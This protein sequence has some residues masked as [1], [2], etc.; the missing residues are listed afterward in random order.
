[1]NKELN[2]GL[3]DKFVNFNY[4]SK[5]TQNIQVKQER[6]L[7][8][9]DSVSAVI[10]LQTPIATK[11]IL[12]L[13]GLFILLILLWAYFS[14]IDTLTR[15]QGQVMTSKQVQIVQNLE[16]GIV[17]DI[18]VTEGQ[19]VK[20]GDVLVKIDDTGFTSTFN[21][22]QLRYDELEA[23]SIR[24]RAESTGGAF[25]TTDEIIKKSPELIRHEESL[26]ISNRQQLNNDITIYNRRL[27]Q[28]RNELKEAQSKVGQLRSNFKLIQKEMQISEPLVKQKIM[29]EVEFIQLQRQMTTIKGELDAVELSIPRLES[30]IEEQKNN[31]QEIEFKF[32]N[33][34]KEQLNETLA[35][36][37]RLQ[38]GNV[39]REDRVKRTN[40]SSPVNGTVKQI[41]V[42]T[43]GGVVKPGMEII[44]I[45]PTQDNLIVEAKIR[46]GDIAFLHPGQKAIVKF[47]A[48]DFAVYGSL[49]GELTHISP[50][51]IVDDVDKQSYYLVRIKT[52]ESYLGNGDKKLDVL[53][54]MTAD[55]DI[56]TGSK[57]ILDFI[58]RPL[59]RAKENVLSER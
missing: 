11:I 5:D 1:M 23:K 50:D 54:G 12:R 58:L 36:M 16:G 20:K 18:L 15:G 6:D 27:Q 39:A 46:P 26:H 37:Q 33:S 13:S 47:S 3:R 25:L 10:L 40:V 49:E 22:N 9:M 52:K 48:Y 7:D 59:L 30:V 45:V 29:S 42:N 24:L 53:V 19:N 43:V 38:S 17:S 28:K 34:A 8:Y 32:R 21:E 4:K 31:L 57:T 2:M 56:V 35:E 44:A 51:T 14:E 41:F 55:V